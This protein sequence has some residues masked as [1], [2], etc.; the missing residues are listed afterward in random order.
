LAALVSSSLLAVGPAAIAFLG[1]QLGAATAPLVTGLIDPREGLV[2]VAVGVLWHG[3]ASD[4]RSVAFARVVLG[5][6]LIA[7]GLQTLRPGF[8]PFVQDPTLLSLV[9]RL[10]SHSLLD[11]GLCASLGALLVAVLQGPAPVVVLVLVLAQT[12]A[13]WDLR[14]ALLALW[15][16]RRRGAAAV[17]WPRST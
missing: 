5:A 3:L 15:S 6:G 11:L 8:E 9:A 12:T 17:A 2:A 1:A 7:V 14:T 4:R 13:Q 16:R 10:K